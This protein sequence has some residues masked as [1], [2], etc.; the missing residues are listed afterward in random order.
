MQGCYVISGKWLY[1]GMHSVLLVAILEPPLQMVTVLEAHCQILLPLS[2]KVSWCGDEW[3]RLRS[4]QPL[5]D[6][7]GVGRGEISTA[8][9]LLISPTTLF[10]GSEKGK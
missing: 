5:G 6:L 8:T 4:G 1:G 2:P 10:C 9:A 7:A 3:N